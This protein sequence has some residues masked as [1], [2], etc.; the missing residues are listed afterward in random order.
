M[1]TVYRPLA[2]SCLL[3]IQ[4]LEGSGFRQADMP[5][6]DPSSSFVSARRSRAEKKENSR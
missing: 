4:G 1:L 6:T 3:D 5:R 2:C